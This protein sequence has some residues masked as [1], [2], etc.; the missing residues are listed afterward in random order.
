MCLPRN[1]FSFLK[2]REFLVFTSQFSLSFHQNILLNEKKSHKTASFLLI[3]KLNRFKFSFVWLAIQVLCSLSCYIWF[4]FLRR[5]GRIWS[6]FSIWTKRF[7]LALYIF[8]TPVKEICL[9]KN[10]TKCQFKSEKPN[11]EKQPLEVFYKKDFFK[12]FK[13]CK[14][15]RKIPVLESLF[16]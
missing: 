15:H 9:G 12:V 1:S 5:T 8:R 11:V 3:E 14:I 7:L 10:A 2:E 4:V 16:Q 6:I 13:S